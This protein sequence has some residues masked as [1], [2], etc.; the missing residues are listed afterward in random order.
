M[1]LHGFLAVYGSALILPLA[2]AEGPVVAVLTGF[3]SAQGYFSWYKASFLLLGGDLIG[4]LIYYWIGRFGAAPLALLGQRWGVRRSVTPEVQRGLRENAA[5]M[6][7]IGKWTHSVGFVVLIGS[8]MLRVNLPRFLLVNLL[9]ALPK[10][11]VLFGFGYF[12]GDHYG[13]FERHVVLT[14]LLLGAAGIAAIAAV[15]RQADGAVAG[16]SDP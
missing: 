1:T 12:A 2:V 8:G 7:V 11:A 5:K 4:D 16:R 9:A 13:F 15:L 3:L 14:T 6:L 10:I